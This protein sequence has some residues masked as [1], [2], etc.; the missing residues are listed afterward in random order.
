LAGGAILAGAGAWMLTHV[1]PSLNLFLKGSA[2]IFV[3][4]GSFHLLLIP[5]FLFGHILLAKLTGIDI[6]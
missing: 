6:G 3:L 5:P 1:A 4:S 2:M